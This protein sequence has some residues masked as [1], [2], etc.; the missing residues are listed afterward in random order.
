MPSERYFL[1]NPLENNIEYVL[2]DQE[3][4]HL[5]HVMRGKAGDCVELVNGKGYL[6]KAKIS[7]LE[8]RRA[9]LLVTE[10]ITEKPPTRQIILA[11]AIPRQN[12]LDMILEKGTELGMT[13]LWL[14]PTHYAD[15]KNFTTHQLE[16]LRSITIAAMKQC[17]RLYL[18]TIVFKPALSQWE[19][20]S[21]LS[22]F[23]DVSPDAPPFIKTWQQQQSDSKSAGQ[24]IMFFVGPESGFSS[25]EVQNLIELN[26]VGVKLHSNI[27]RTD[28]AGI[29]ALSLISHQ[30][31]TL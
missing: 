7:R 27:L 9:I 17:G 12:R 14:F 28:T 25:E 20:L 30:L 29:T 5:V 16:R 11:Q 21:M 15:K 8:K 24:G 10:I 4:H 18:P 19:P 22:Y 13:Q 1:D 3:F 26:S 31:L 2:D 23:G 6:A